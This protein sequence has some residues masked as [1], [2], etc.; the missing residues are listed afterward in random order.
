VAT[1]KAQLIEIRRH[2]RA[3]DARRTADLDRGGE[4]ASGNEAG[5][6]ALRNRKRTGGLLESQERGLLG[7]GNWWD[8]SLHIRLELPSGFDARSAEYVLP[9]ANSGLMIF[10]QNQA[11]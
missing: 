11:L 4:S 6:R 8:C 3:E 9:I 2:V 7:L 1:L 5:E 10:A